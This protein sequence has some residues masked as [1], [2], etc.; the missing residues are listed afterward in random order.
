MKI[1]K[2]HSTNTHVYPPLGIAVF[3]F[4][5]ASTNKSVSSSNRNHPLTSSIEAAIFSKSVYQGYNFFYII[6]KGIRNDSGRFQK[7]S[8]LACKFN[9]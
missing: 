6:L 8:A 5:Y 9:K 2:H 3:F 7:T 4:F 1:I